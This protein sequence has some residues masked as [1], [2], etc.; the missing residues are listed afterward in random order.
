MTGLAF[1][2]NGGIKRRQKSPVS[3]AVFPETCVGL[4]K[5]PTD[6]ELISQDILPPASIH[7]DTT[8]QK[9]A[10]HELRTALSRI[11]NKESTT[12]NPHNS[13]RP[14]S[15]CSLNFL[16]YRSRARG[17]EERQIRVAAQCHFGDEFVFQ[18]APVHDPSL[19]FHRPRVL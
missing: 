10:Y 16:C 3:V 2:E 5:L 14:N 19:I 7:E 17:C 12:P 4:V 15:T 6:E 1:W 9:G 11:F 13:K 18:D 8:D